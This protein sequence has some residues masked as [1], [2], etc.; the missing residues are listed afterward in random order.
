[1]EHLGDITTNGSVVGKNFFEDPGLHRT[2]IGGRALRTM[3]AGFIGGPANTTYGENTGVLA[4]TKNYNP[5]ILRIAAVYAIVLSFIGYFGGIPKNDTD[6]D[7]WRDEHSALRNDS[8]DRYKDDGR[9][10]SRLY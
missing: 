8:C 2:L 10:Q 4:I 9:S 6:A 5:A 7:S 1:M 3:F